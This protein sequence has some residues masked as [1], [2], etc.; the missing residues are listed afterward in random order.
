MC[1]AEYYGVVYPDGYIDRR[2]R[3]VHCR[4]G[5]RSS[6]C[7][8]LEHDEDAYEE[9][10]AT[11]EEIM[12]RTRPWLPVN[13]PR[14]ESSVRSETTSEASTPKDKLRKL[15]GMKKKAKYAPDQETL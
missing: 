2:Q 8:N 6:Q 11:E 5:T 4:R 12:A 10:P 9:R 3:I 13:T 7:P 15:F 14:P 1:R